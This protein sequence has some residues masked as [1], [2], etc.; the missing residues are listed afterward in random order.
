[1]TAEPMLAGVRVIEV[2][3]GDSPTAYAGRILSQL[4]ADVLCIEPPEGSSLRSYGPFPDGVPDREK[5]ALF[6]A[7]NFNKTGVTLNLA[8]ATGRTILDSL[9]ANVDVLI[10]SGDARLKYSKT[11]LDPESLAT[12][13]PAL[14]AACVSTFGSEGP[15]QSW[16]G[17]DLLAS[18]AGGVSVGIG[19]PGQV[20]LSLPGE[21][22]STQGGLAA[23]AGVLASLVGRQH[24]GLGDWV[25]AA[26]CDVWATIHCNFILSFVYGHITG[27]RNGVRR[28]GV[29]PNQAFP[30]KDGTVFIEC[31]QVQQWV[32]FVEMMGTPAWSELPRYRDRRAMGSEYPEEV[33]ALVIPWL[34]QF[35][36]EELWATSREYRVPLTPVYSVEELVRHPHLLFRRFFLEPVWE[37]RQIQLPGLPFQLTNS[38]EGKI[39]PSPTLGQDN[40][41]IYEGL[42]YTREELIRMKAAEVI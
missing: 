9:L 25:D 7:L 3:D 16:K 26:A 18:A 31:L 27:M 33:D 29:Y 36:R 24:D 8:T 2:A 20:P 39:G 21:V 23:V 11:K 12:K 22:A 42:G 38:S 32:R 4:G 13:F 28:G 1:M 6:F 34:T 35:T 14:V 40:I 30:C 41:R 10:F 5:S 15:W 17:G 37:G 19:R